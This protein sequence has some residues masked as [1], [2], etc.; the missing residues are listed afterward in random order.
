[1]PIPADPSW[2]TAHGARPAALAPALLDRVRGG[3]DDFGR[4]GPGSRWRWL[5]DVH[6]PECAAHDAA[7]RGELARGSHPVIAH[8]K[9]LPRLPAAIGSYVRARLRR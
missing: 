2:L 7:V 4:C 3:V 9:A 6:T 8:G 5:G 1:M